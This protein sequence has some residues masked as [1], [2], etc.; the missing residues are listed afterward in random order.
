MSLTTTIHVRPKSV[1][2]LR[3]GKDVHLCPAEKGGLPVEVDLTRWEVTFHY[4]SELH[5]GFTKPEEP[6]DLVRVTAL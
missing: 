6:E 5:D 1:N 4:S 2:K 3:K